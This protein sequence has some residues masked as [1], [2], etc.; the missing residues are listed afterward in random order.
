MAAKKPPAKKGAKSPA[1][2]SGEDLRPRLSAHPRAQRQI[3]EA[4]AWAAIVGFGLVG[5]LSLQAGQEP[6]DAGV[7]ALVAGIVCYVTG[8]GLAVSVWAHL[9]RAEVK[10]VEQRIAEQ[11][12]Q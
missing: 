12:A 8:W 4:K 2:A 10:V 3:R 7:R 11:R 5:L 6:F 1:K 9:A